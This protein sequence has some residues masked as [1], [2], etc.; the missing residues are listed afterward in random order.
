MIVSPELIKAHMYHALDIMESIVASNMTQIP[1]S[2]QG[3]VVFHE[4]GDC[5]YDGTNKT[6][7]RVIAAA[8]NVAVY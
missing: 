8:F 7:A 4:C 3:Y 6:I 2:H 1:D 5:L